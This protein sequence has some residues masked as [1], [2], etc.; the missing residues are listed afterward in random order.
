[1]WTC[2]AP[3]LLGKANLLEFDGQLHIRSWNSYSTQKH[4]I[5]NIETNIHRLGKIKIKKTPNLDMQT[6]KQ[7]EYVCVMW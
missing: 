6:S 7:G 2:L 4:V 5:K 3:T 1:M